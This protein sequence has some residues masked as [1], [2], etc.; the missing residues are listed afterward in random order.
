MLLSG[1]QYTQ[2]QKNSMKGEKEV[3]KAQFDLLKYLAI[4]LI[5][6]FPILFGLIIKQPALDKDFKIIIPL[7]FLLLVGLFAV[8]KS[9]KTLFLRNSDLTIDI[10][11]FLLLAGLSNVAFGLTAGLFFF[12]ENPVLLALFDFASIMSAV[13]MSIVLFIIVI[14]L[15]RER[16]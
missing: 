1:F 9:L 8:Y 15:G 11:I 7:V 6:A 5:S 10:L 14:A 13:V 4:G 2:H 16:G 3:A 12:P